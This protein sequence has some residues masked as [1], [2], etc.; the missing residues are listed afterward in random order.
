MESLFYGCLPLCSLDDISKWN[1]SNVY[2]ISNMYNSCYSLVNIEP[3]KKLNV[4]KLKCVS[5]IFEKCYSLFYIGDFISKWNIEE[6]NDDDN[7]MFED[8][9]N[10]INPFKFYRNIEI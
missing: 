5:Y 4:D 7:N 1:I 9:F 10:V 2:N 6:L 8:C 3:I